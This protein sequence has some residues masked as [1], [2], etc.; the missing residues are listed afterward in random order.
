MESAVR[1]ISDREIP[2]IDSEDI[3]PDPTSGLNHGPLFFAHH[4]NIQWSHLPTNHP[5][6]TLSPFMY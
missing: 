2:F 3:P 4:N 5:F 6:S 1:D